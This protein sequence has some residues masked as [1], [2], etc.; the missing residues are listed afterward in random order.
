VD[1]KAKNDRC[2]EAKHCVRPFVQQYL[3]F[4][5]VTDEDRMAAWVHNHDSTHTPIGAPASRPAI[6]G[7]KAL[8]G[9]QALIP[10]TIN[11]APKAGQSPTAVTD[12][13]CIT[14]LAPRR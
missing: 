7:L 4:D 5:P 2:A 8:G 14:P 9:F 13:S 3:K 6:A 12:A 10:S 1:T 11:T